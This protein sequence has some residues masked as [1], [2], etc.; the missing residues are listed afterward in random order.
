MY[1]TPS[2]LLTQP[3]MMHVPAVA[4]LVDETI[5]SMLSPVAS[6]AKLQANESDQQSIP[7]VN[8]AIYDC[9]G[10]KLMPEVTVNEDGQKC[11]DEVQ[12]EGRES[13]SLIAVVPI[14]GVLT[15]HGYRG[16]Y[17]SSAGMLEIGRMLQKMDADEAI[18]TIV[19]Y[20]NSPGGTVTGTPELAE[21]V[22]GIRQGK[23]TKILSVVD[24]MMASAATYIGSAAER[25]YSIPSA[26][27]G[28]IGV[29]ISYTSYADALEKAG[30]A[31]DYLRTPEKK[32]RFTGVEPLTD[33]MRETL[34]ERIDSTM[35]WF[36]AAMAKHRGVTESYVK[37]AFGQGE[38]MRADE[39][40]DSKLIDGI[41][42]L[43]DVVL[44][45]ASEIRGNRTKTRRKQMS[46]QIED[47]VAEQEELSE[48]VDGPKEPEPAK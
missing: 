17:S 43:D 39:A 6:S 25:V 19:L 20:I 10:Q 36:V 48:I 45:Q 14:G 33:E 4:T 46:Q 47:A 27:S 21:I 35:D 29:V 38:V 16:Y 9:E 2:Q 1:T 30:I 8:V 40:V 31:V 28:S 32:A 26:Y 11:I 24:E 41:M 5:R 3:L 18:H 15:R 22:Y 44:Q 13:Q 12:T 23:R 37:K 42:S 7:K 34:Q